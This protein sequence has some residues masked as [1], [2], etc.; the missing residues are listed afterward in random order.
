MKFKRENGFTLFELVAYILVVS[1]TASVAYNRF[2]SFPGAAERANFLAVMTQ[3]KSGVT[4]QMMA[5]V[6]RGNWA[7]LGALEGSNPMDL[8]LETPVN[9][10]GELSGYSAE[11][12]PG[13]VWYFNTASKEL[14]YIASDST[15]LYRVIDGQ[16]VP[17]NTVAFQ[18]SM[19]F[20]DAG[21][22]NWQGLVL[23]PAVPF[24]WES[25]DLTIPG[26]VEP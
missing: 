14:V 1:I 8:M 20:T 24:V 5:A 25:I 10:M 12:M 4:M 15:D 19:K 2:G 6:A 11:T 16:R 7:E 23:E 3:L 26:V 21:R 22:S 9:Y 18:I 17:T 13:R